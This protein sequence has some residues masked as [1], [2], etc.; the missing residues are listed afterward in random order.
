VAQRVKDTA[1]HIYMVD[2][3]ISRATVRFEGADAAA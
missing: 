2:Y 3:V 1:A